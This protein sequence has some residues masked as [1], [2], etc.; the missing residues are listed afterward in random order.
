MTKSRRIF[1]FTS[2][3]ISAGAVSFH[4]VSAE[5][6]RPRSDDCLVDILPDGN[7]DD[8]VMDG[9]T[10]RDEE[11]TVPVWTYQ[12]GV[13]RC[14]GKGYGFLR[15]KKELRDFTFHVEFLMLD[16]RCN[17]GIC[18]R[19]VPYKK[20]GARPSSSG[21][22]LQIRSDAGKKTRTKSSASLYRYVAPKVNA[23]KRPGEW[24][25]I[26]ITCRGPMIH[27]VLNGQVIH[28]FDQRSLE[29]TKEKPLCG[30][31]SLQNHGKKIHF[32]NVRLKE[33]PKPE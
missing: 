18:I 27:V 14:N 21:Y 4:P 32:R 1:L 7:M 23:I 20:G 9:Q 30:Y 11:K 33:Y 2:L 22:E 28:N 15:Y 19:H 8:W 10:H 29:A 6:N 17:S 16:S 12:D 3:A 24:N 25:V 13:L 31:I 5:E 26:D